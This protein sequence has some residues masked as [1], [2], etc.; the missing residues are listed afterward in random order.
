MFIISARLAFAFGLDTAHARRVVEQ[1]T[2][3]ILQD[4]NYDS[5][6]LRP[7][8]PDGIVQLDL[9]LARRTG[10]PFGVPANYAQGPWPW[11]LDRG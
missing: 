4:L 2:F 7:V 11:V 6:L 1:K 9:D 8:C 5:R 3:I 10:N